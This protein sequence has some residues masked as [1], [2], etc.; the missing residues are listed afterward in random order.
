MTADVKTLA[1][2]AQTEPHKRL[3]EI[4]IE[5]GLLTEVSVRRLIGHAK[6]KNFR[7]GALLEVIGLITP[8]ELAEALAIQYRC[9]TIADFAKHPF[10][11]RTLR[12]IPMETA[13][14]N[15]IFPL[16][17]DNG[18]LGLA[19]AD[20]TMEKLFS[21]IST[22]LNVRVIPFVS[23]RSEINRAIARH[24]L[25]QGIVESDAKTILLVEDDELV[26]ISVTKILQ[27][28][29]YAV[30]TAVDGMDAFNKIFTLRP[31]LVITDKVMPKLSGYDFL[32]AVRKIP[33]FR[34]TPFILMTAAATPNEEKEALEKGFFDF[35]LK[36]VKDI[37]L[38]TRVRRAFQSAESLYG[39]T[40]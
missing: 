3:G 8:W 20:P 4:F 13:V 9:K 39:M 12:L 31:K 25:G 30:E 28:Q 23:T 36:P 35:V 15:T 16:K 17:I 33:E 32:Y 22:Q 19:V 14:E 7:L 26:R 1:G 5:R 24:Y 38:L 27:R 40:G 10:P 29:G 37:G 21:A 18:R 6:S 34:Y 11:E 2:A